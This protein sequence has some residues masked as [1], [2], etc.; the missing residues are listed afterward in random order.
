[1]IPE[2]LAWSLIQDGWILRNKIIWYKPNGMPSSVKDR[3]SNKYEFVYMFCKAKERKVGYQDISEINKAWLAALIDGEGTIGIANKDTEYQP[4]LYVGNTN[5]AL[6]DKVIEITG[7]DNNTTSK[8]CN[9][10]TMWMFR[11]SSIKAINIIKQIYPY[12][13][14][15]KEQAKVAIKLQESSIRGGAGHGQ[16]KRIEERRKLYELIKALNQCLVEN[17]GLPHPDL[18]LPQRYYGCEKYY[19]DLDA[20]REPF[21]YPERTYNPDTSNH[22]TYQLKQNGNRTTGGLHDGRTQYGNPELGKN[23]G[24]VFEIPTQ[25]FPGAHFAVFPEKLCEK[26]I[27]AGCPEGGT[28]LDPFC[29]AGTT[30]YVAKEMGR[31]Y[32]GIDIKEE[33]IQLTNKRLVQDTLW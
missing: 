3:F 5:K 11:T 8:K 17:A 10:K 28:V 7:L 12:L 13:I 6:I 2:R 31:Q 27:K 24:D 22:V 15:K 25:P 33:Y 19:F 16:P 32:I 1:M 23:P 9:N 18:S 21:H 26:P 29:G 30:C 4:Y 20:V 14:A